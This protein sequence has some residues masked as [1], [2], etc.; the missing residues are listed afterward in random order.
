M[1]DE[2]PRKRS[3]NALTPSTDEPDARFAELAQRYF[4]TVESMDGTQVFNANG[5]VAT[6]FEFG[7]QMAV[8]YEPDED[9]GFREM[10]DT[11]NF[12]KGVATL[13][14]VPAYIGMVF[15]LEASLFLSVQLIAVANAFLPYVLIGILTI[16]FTAVLLFPILMQLKN[17]DWRRPLS[18][19][20][21]PDQVVLGP[22][23]LSLRWSGSFVSMM[24]FPLKWCDMELVYLEDDRSGASNLCVRD[25]KGGVLRLKKDA[26]AN[27]EEFHVFKES[28]KAKAQQAAKQ[29]SSALLVQPGQSEQFVYVWKW[30]WHLFVRANT[31]VEHKECDVG[32]VLHRRYSIV[33]KLGNN[34]FCNLYLAAS[35]DD[36]A[37]K[38][39]SSL[40]DHAQRQHL[41]IPTV[42][43]KEYFLPQFENWFKYER[44]LHALEDAS[45][46]YTTVSG[47]GVVYW[48][49]HFVENHRL[50][51]VTENVQGKNLRQLIEEGGTLS[52]S[53]AVDVVLKMCQPIAVMHERSQFNVWNGRFEVSP[54]V[55][56]QMTPEEFV[57]DD[58]GAIRLLD[59]DITRQ[60]IF[61][62][63][64]TILGHAS[65]L[66]PEQLSG[67]ST[68]Q[69][70]IYAIGKIM[71]FLLTRR[72]PQPFAPAAPRDEN[73]RI[74]E[75]LNQIVLKATGT[76]PWERYL[77]IEDL[78]AD[79]TE[80]RGDRHM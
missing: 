53:D 1:V 67:T 77:D 60:L 16:L 50:Y 76:D 39:F 48:L 63:N 22:Y 11:I 27:A 32:S 44:M 15:A 73:E 33:E 71:Y 2:T 23:G 40:E 8:S 41:E 64:D 35:I 59:K 19:F 30:L 25:K 36:N 65:Y 69:S 26:F 6:P 28:I 21:K 62:S 17:F 79:L 58:A 14:P 51:V 29:K 57:V 72:D 20:W 55:H 34:G 54:L 66:G 10:R 43:V 4:A 45:R 61:G 24:S 18:V 78:I 74:S 7:A 38:R 13:L 46:Q 70:D 9:S 3:I 42:R 56:G 68:V 5:A 37:G 80:L 31:A 52:E 12:R 75:R 47:K 49:D